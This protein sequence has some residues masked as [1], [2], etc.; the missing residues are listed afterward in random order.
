MRLCLSAG[1]I[2]TTNNE[3]QVVADQSPEALK[4]IKGLRRAENHGRCR[5]PGPNHDLGQGQ[6]LNP[7]T[8]EA[9]K[10][11]GSLG[12]IVI[13]DPLHPLHV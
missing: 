3:V 4:G 6:D 7:E 12:G 8:S 2:I 9:R 11:T 5:A 13:Q 10:L 1:I